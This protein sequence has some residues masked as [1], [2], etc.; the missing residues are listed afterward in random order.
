MNIIKKE[1]FLVIENYL[2]PD[3]CNKIVERGSVLALNTATMFSGYSQE[4]RNSRVGWF[5]R[6][7]D[8]DIVSLIYEAA[9]IFKRNIFNYDIN[10]IN[11]MQF[12]LYE[13]TPQNVAKYDWHFD[14]FYNN[15]SPFDR[16]I[17]FVLQLSNPYEYE[18]G[19]FEFQSPYE[20][21]IP[22]AKNKGSVILFPS[23]IPHRVTG[24]T[25]GT[26]KSLVSWVEGPKFR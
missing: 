21:M 23:F 15:D 22:E 16:K 8:S 17:S 3:E 7:H 12:T 11:D 9:L 25:S 10:Y 6:F 1:T 20:E 24:V 19:D 26:R 4:Y 5:N 2:T 18:G 14:I 13:G